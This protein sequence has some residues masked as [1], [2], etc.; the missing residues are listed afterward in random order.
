MYSDNPKHQLKLYKKY[1]YSIGRFDKRNRAYA[2]G[3]S[4]GGGG[5]HAGASHQLW[6]GANGNRRKKPHPNGND[7]H[8]HPPPPPPTPPLV[9]MPLIV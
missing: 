3:K 4:W 5:A 8:M 9:T 6:G 1:I 7:V 2:T